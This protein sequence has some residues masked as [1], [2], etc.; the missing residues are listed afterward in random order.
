MCPNNAAR[1]I[2]IVSFIV[3]LVSVVS[4]LQLRL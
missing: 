2:L 3:Y 4:L 1:E